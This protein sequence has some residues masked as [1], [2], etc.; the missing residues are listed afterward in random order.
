MLEFKFSEINPLDET[1]ILLKGT[2]LWI[3]NVYSV[4]PHV[5]L[6]SM[7]K[8]FSLKANRK[9]CGLDTS[10]CVEFINQRLMPTIFVQVS[11]RMQLTLSDV[12][13]VFDNYFSMEL[14]QSTCLS[15]ISELMKVPADVR[16][17]A[18]LLTYLKS[19]NY[20]EAFFSLNLR[21]S[22]FDLPKYDFNDI[23]NHIFEL[24]NARR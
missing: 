1:E 16:Q 7:G 19:N 24:K 20:L 11:P 9:E 4:P 10:S 12:Q 14:N 5:G 15:P 8:Y 22:V 6:S 2:F 23:Q 3:W 18:Q 21:G 13:S 17:L